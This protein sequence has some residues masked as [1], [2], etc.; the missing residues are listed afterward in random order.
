MFT[1]RVLLPHSDVSTVTTWIY[2]GA[3]V[4]V[5]CAFEDVLTTV[6]GVWRELES[7]ILDPDGPRSDSSSSDEDEDRQSRKP[8]LKTDRK[9]RDNNS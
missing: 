1:V 2:V 4:L 7:E 6:H 9:S 8:T 3:T 5:L